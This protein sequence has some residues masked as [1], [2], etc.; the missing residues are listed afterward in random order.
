M[1]R[2]AAAAYLVRKDAEDIAHRYRT[3]YGDAAVIDAELDE[4][5]GEGVWP[6]D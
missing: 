4:W 6:Q 2:E 1:L 3:G 5:T